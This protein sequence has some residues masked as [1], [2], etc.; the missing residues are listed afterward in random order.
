M[1]RRYSSDSVVRASIVPLV[2]AV[3]FIVA[4]ALIFVFR[5]QLGNNW[6]FVLGYLLTPIGVIVMLGT[7]MSRQRKGQNNP[8][9][10]I[11]P[12]YSKALRWLAGLSFLVAIL[13]ILEIGFWVGRIA[14][15]AGVGS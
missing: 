12:Q 4:S 1:A 13:H 7:D 10:D 6:F 9:F 14:V 3:L 11:R 2:L 15:Q 5:L 8:N